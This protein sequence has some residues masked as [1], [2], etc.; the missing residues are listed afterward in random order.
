MINPN[1]ITNYQRTEG[2]LQEF[3]LFCVMCA[4]KSSTVQ[5]QK[6]SHFLSLFSKR[7]G[8]T[9]FERLRGLS[10]ETMLRY[11]KEAKVGKYKLIGDCIWLISPAHGL[12]D[13][14]T[15]NIDPH[16]KRKALIE[17]PGIG[18]KTASLFLLHSER[19]SRMAVLDTHLLK[20]LRKLYPKARIPKAS[21]QS[22]DKY[23]EIEDMWLGYC[24]RNGHDPATH[25]LNVWKEK[26][27]KYDT[28]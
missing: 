1:Y 16:E 24:Y 28:K 6:L 15:W 11:L 3:L 5:A 8:W 13:L 18:I 12:C 25:D 26:G 17:C 9:H 23:R 21:P 14:H 27:K 19:D 4:G 2:Q 22:M 10:K 20:Y 7:P